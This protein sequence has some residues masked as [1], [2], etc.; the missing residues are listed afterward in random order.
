F[1]P[2][3]G[4]VPDNMRAAGYE[5]AQVDTIFITHLHPDHVCGLLTTDGKR[6]SPNA[7]VRVAQADAAYWVSDAVAAEMPDSAQPFFDMAQASIT[8]YVE[9]DQ[10][11]TFT[12]GDE[13]MPGVSSVAEI[14]HTPG[15]TAYLVDGPEHDLL[16]W[17][18]IVHNFAV[19]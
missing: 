3:L 2:T 16:I 12:A 17:G 7:E 13:L 5:L 18:D 19:Q 14:G 10:F 1:G 9:A 6:A 4:N 11:D 8:P 15:H